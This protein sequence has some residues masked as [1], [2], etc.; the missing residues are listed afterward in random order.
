MDFLYYFLSQTSSGG[1][2]LAELPT[3]EEWDILKREELNTGLR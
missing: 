1:K 2:N 3:P